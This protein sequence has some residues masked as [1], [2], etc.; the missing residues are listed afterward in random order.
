[1]YT[2]CVY[3]AYN[4]RPYMDYKQLVQ[5]QQTNGVDMG[6]TLHGRTTCTDMI[7]CIAGNMRQSICQFIIKNNRKKQLLWMNPHQFQKNLA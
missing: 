4:N 1:M 2:Q 3:V 6:H 5:L 7:S